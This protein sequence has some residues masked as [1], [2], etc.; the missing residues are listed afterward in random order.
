MAGTTPNHYLFTGEQHD[1]L[2]G[3]VYLRARYYDPNSGRFLTQ[4]TW[5]GQRGKPITL[6]KYLYANTNPAVFI[7]PTGQFGMAQ[8]NAITSMVSIMVRASMGTI[9]RFFKRIMKKKKSDK[10]KFKF[11]RGTQPLDGLEKLAIIPLFKHHFIFVEPIV[12]WSPVATGI[13]YDPGPEDPN[14]LQAVGPI[15]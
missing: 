1:P 15:S 11:F 2:T 12:K 5:Q 6:H 14:A 4:D 13:V 10:E 7:D 8:V 3:L 9:S